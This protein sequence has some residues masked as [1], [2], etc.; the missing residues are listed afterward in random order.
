LQFIWATFS[1]PS[2]S[3]EIKRD[4]DLWKN[5]YDYAQKAREP[6]HVIQDVARIA[7]LAETLVEP[8]LYFLAGLLADY[9]GLGSSRAKTY[10]QKTLELDQNHQDA[11]TALAALAIR[12]N[13]WPNAVKLLLWA[14]RLGWS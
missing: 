3:K 12:E 9:S 4:I 6:A 8:S 7:E 5:H 11:T 10:F 13:D 1:L 14:V 2:L